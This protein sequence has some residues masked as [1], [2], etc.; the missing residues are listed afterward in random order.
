MTDRFSVS[1]REVIMMENVKIPSGNKLLTAVVHVPA[2]IS[3]PYLFVM[4]HGFRGSKDG[5]GKAV[6]MAELA[7]KAGYP[8]IRFD[9]TPLA[10]LSVQI[11]ELSDVL[12]YGRAR[13]GLPVIGMGRSMGGCAL[14]HC[15]RSESDIAGL[16]FW[17]MP[18]SLTKTMKRALGDYYDELMTR[19]R[20]EVNDAYGHMVLERSFWDDL[21]HYDMDRTVRSITNRPA[22][23]IHGKE[24]DIV[25]VEEG[26]MN[27]DIYCGEKEWYA[28]EGADHHIAV[29]IETTQARL[30]DWMIQHFSE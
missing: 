8:V 3:R 25:L 1:G 15:A 30:L 23:F 7:C 5:G 13:F 4:C 22:I 20:I 19:G 24:D 29:D 12:A 10:P 14:A 17:A 21:S 27:Y 11:E 6:R 18:N 28:V 16:C 2:I 9:F 26:K